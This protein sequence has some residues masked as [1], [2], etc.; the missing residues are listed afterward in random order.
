MQTD[1]DP[2]S[3]NED[4]DEMLSRALEESMAQYNQEKNRKSIESNIRSNLMFRLFD[5][6]DANC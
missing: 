6:Q 1:K 3:D 4:E 2:F 5:W